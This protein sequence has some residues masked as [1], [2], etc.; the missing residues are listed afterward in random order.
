[1]TELESNNILRMHGERA[2]FQFLGNDGTALDNRTIWYIFMVFKKPTNYKQIIVDAGNAEIPEWNVISQTQNT[3][4][5]R[6]NGDVGNVA[7]EIKATKT[8][9]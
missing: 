8:T 7:L 3:C 1:V 9:N 2:A 5:I 4:I 6:F